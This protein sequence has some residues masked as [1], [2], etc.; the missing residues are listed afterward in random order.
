M[1]EIIA[2]FGFLIGL[3]ALLVSSEAMRR[4]SQRCL[5]L[6][7]QMFKASQR[8]TRLESETGALRRQYRRRQETLI[9][10]ERKS[11]HAAEEHDAPQGDEYPT[12][13][14]RTP[15][16]RYVPSQFLDASLRR[17]G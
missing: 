3:S 14:I 9:A 17:S 15:Q 2:L 6:E 8:I 11:R 4:L 12:E 10:L 1:V 7:A 13:D 5:H 16:Q